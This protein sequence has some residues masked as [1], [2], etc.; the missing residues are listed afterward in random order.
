M[1]TGLE[2][3]QQERNEQIHKHNIQI[4]HDVLKNQDEELKKIAIALLTNDHSEFPENWNFFKKEKLLNNKSYKQR[5]I[6]AGA[7]IAA[8]IDRLNALEKLK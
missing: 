5:L 3:I 2:E 1:K 8:E 7:L 4:Q 6:V